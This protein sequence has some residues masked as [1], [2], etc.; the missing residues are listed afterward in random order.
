M[1]ISPV[2]VIIAILNPNSSAS[3]VGLPPFAEEQICSKTLILRAK[4]G[5]PRRPRGRRRGRR[6][7]KR[8]GG[9]SKDNVLPLDGLAELADEI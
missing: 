1:S 3:R 7:S 6:G 8:G 2:A 4:A 5:P 9:G